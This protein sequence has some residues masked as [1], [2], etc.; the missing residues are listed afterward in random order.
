M[1]QNSVQP[2]AWGQVAGQKS[3]WSVSLE[4]HPCPNSQAAQIMVSEDALS[5]R[6]QY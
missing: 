1:I 4:P 5:L 6:V 2:A 3:V